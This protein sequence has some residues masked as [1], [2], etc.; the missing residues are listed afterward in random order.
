[1]LS[2]SVQYKSDEQALFIK[3]KMKFVKQIRKM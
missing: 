3:Q 2:S 1:M